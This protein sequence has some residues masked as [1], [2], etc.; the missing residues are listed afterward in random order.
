MCRDNWHV[1]GHDWPAYGFRGETEIEQ[2][3][4]V[5]HNASMRLVLQERRKLV[6]TICLT[7]RMWR[8]VAVAAV[9][10]AILDA[11]SVHKAQVNDF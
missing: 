1:L 10:E 2:R 5:A 6:A 4:R 3:N 8:D 11:S 9:A 7:C